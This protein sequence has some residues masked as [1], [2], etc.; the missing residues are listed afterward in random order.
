MPVFHIGRDPREIAFANQLG[1]RPRLLNPAGQ[2]AARTANAPAAGRRPETVGRRDS[3]RLSKV[4]SNDTRGDG[5]GRGRDF[6]APPRLY[7]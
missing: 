5:S 4:V 3:T 6:V 2:S 7:T 1:L